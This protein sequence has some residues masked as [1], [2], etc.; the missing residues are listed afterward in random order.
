M[1]LLSIVIVYLYGLEERTHPDEHTIP[2]T[3]TISQPDDITCGPACAA[4][5]LRHYGK[6]VTV[7]QVKA[8]TKTV[9]FTHRSQDI[10]MTSPDYLPVAMNKLGVPSQMKYGNIDTLKHYVAQ[11]RPCIALVRSGERLWH[12]IVIRGFTPDKVLVADPSGGELYDMDIDK[13]V[14]CWS[15]DA[16][17]DGQPC[18]SDY[19]VTLLRV[20]EV[21]PYTFICPDRPKE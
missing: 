16:D 19:I 14:G 21:Y 3:T 17:M 1:L 20:A 9:W 10:G 8:L 11:G 2:F 15:W 6:E 4:M 13:F 12:Y 5:I 7:E 18:G